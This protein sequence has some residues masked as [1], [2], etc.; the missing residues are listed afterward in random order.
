MPDPTSPLLVRW[1]PPTW[2]RQP[3]GMTWEDWQPWQPWMR[4]QGQAW[5]EWAYNIRLPVGDPP[6]PLPD[7][8]SD[9]LWR[10]QTAKRIDAVARR[11]GQYWIFEARRTPGY[12]A[13]GQLLGYRDLWTLHHPQLELA[14]L[15]LVTET[16]DDSIRALAARQGIRTWCVSDH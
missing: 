13:V 10:E 8:E 7:P 2:A 12:S 11:N 5:P 9:R 4:V 1:Y 14:A 16:C 3:P 6:T 15:Y